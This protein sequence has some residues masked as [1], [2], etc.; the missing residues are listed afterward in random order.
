MTTKLAGTISYVLAGIGFSDETIAHTLKTCSTLD[1]LDDLLY[2][3]AADYVQLTTEVLL[4]EDPN[5]F[6]RA[7][8]RQFLQLAEWFYEDFGGP[9][10]SWKNFNRSTFTVWKRQKAT[11][12]QDAREASSRPNKITTATPSTLFDFSDDVMEKDAEHMA[13]R[14]MPGS[15][16]TLTP[17]PLWISPCATMVRKPVSTRTF[18]DTDLALLS[19]DPTVIVTFYRHLVHSPSQQRSTYVRKIR[20]ILL[21][22]CGPKIGVLKLF[23]K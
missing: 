15:T 6:T 10:F 20:S 4:L 3:F 14:A 22:L 18:D 12:A 1:S 21:I 8:V 16:A 2:D 7:H 23:L 5:D 17:H 19:D 11:D 9:S 13:S